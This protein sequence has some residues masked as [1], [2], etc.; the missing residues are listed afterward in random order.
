M[1]QERKKKNQK[2]LPFERPVSYRPPLSATAEDATLQAH[3]SLREAL[4]C[5]GKFMKYC[6]KARLRGERAAGS[7]R[8][9]LTLLRP[10]HPVLTPPLKHFKCHTAQPFPAPYEKLRQSLKYFKKKIPKGYGLCCLTM[11]LAVSMWELI[12]SGLLPFR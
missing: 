6:G 1:L 8:A 9:R 3:P 5:A 4:T 12:G 2:T 7:Q 11:M 10:P